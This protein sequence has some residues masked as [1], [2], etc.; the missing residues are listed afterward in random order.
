MLSAG[1]KIKLGKGGVG[2]NIGGIIETFAITVIFI[3]II[4]RTISNVWWE[5]TCT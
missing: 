5:P 4:F 1:K 3:N 2:K